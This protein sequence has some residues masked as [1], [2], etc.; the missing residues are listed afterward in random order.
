MVVYLT[1]SFISI[2]ETVAYGKEA[3]SECYGFFEDLKKE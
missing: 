2:P 1:S 3:P